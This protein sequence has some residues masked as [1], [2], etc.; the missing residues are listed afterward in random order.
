MRPLSQA[1]PG[2][3]AHLLRDAPPS[4]GKAGFAWSAAVG[5]AVDRATRVTLEG[6]VL[7]VEVTSAQW[8]REIGRSR[9]LIIARLQALLGR[10]NLTAIS[11]RRHA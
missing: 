10:D 6:T 7:V 2:A 9:R 4:N 11:I 1:V 5:P 3:I 8:A